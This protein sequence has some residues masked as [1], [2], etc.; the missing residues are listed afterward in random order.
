LS[1]NSCH[2]S[3][4][5]IDRATPRTTCA[6]CHNTDGGKPN[7][8]SCHVQHIRDSRRWSNPQITQTKM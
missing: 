5:P 3:F 4:D 8:T 2:R 6:M 1:C 7:C